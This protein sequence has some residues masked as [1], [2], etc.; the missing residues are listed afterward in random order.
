MRF[1]AG[2]PQELD[3]VLDEIKTAGPGAM[4]V[5]SDPNLLSIRAK[6]LAF[7]AAQ[8]LP[9]I[10]GNADYMPDGVPISTRSGLRGPAC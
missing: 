7:A 8:R 5:E 9:T 10:Y 6:I 1:G 3:R 4:I 2:D